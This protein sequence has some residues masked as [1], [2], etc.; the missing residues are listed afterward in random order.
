MALAAERKDAH[1]SE[2][3][4]K[5]SCSE[6]SSKLA[7]SQEYWGPAVP[8]GAAYQIQVPAASYSNP[9]PAIEKPPTCLGSRRHVV[10]RTSLWADLEDEAAWDTA[11]RADREAPVVLEQ[12][13]FDLPPHHTT[14]RLLLKIGGEAD[15]PALRLRWVHELAD[16]RED[17]SNGLIMFG[18]FF[19]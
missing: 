9:N 1:R 12:A 11:Q 8:A 2:L 7:G 13:R 17:G 5:S 14:L 3:A 6:G 18:E 4:P 19:I 15:R 16:G 10:N